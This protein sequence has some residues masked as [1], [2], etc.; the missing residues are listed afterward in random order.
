VEIHDP[1]TGAPVPAGTVGEICVRGPNVSPGYVRGGAQGLARRDGWLQ[2]GDLGVAEADGTITFRGLCKPMF[3]RNGF[4]IYPREIEQAVLA[5]PGVRG[6][7]VR[8]IP[9][10][11]REHDIGLDVAGEVTAEAVRR[12]CAERLSAY[13]QPSEVTVA[14]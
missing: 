14:S 1:A 5:L 13:K 7:A 4:N 8:A 6:V 3:T 10:P 11:A 12:W 9:E 2:T